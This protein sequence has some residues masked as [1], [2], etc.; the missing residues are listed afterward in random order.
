MASVIRR[1]HA[2]EEWTAAAGAHGVDYDFVLAH[3][4]YVVGVEVHFLDA[5]VVAALAWMKKAWGSAVRCTGVGLAS[6]PSERSQSWSPAG[7]VLV[8]G[9]FLEAASA[10]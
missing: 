10:A 2:A 7:R 3:G 6:H 8:H 4:Q 1:V 5:T 9:V